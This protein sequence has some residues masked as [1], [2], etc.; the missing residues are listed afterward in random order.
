M[1]DQAPEKQKPEVEPVPVIPVIPQTKPEINPSPEKH[2]DKPA[3]EITPDPE[4]KTK[5][6]KET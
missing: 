6:G 1:K 4:P 2:E 5:P 3:P